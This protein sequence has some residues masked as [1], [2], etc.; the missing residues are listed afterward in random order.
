MLP[1]LG[2]PQTSALF[3]TVYFHYL[4]VRITLGF[5][6]AGQ[7]LG[8]NPGRR[9]VTPLDY[10][11]FGQEPRSAKANSDEPTY[12]RIIIMPRSS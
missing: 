4:S 1:V 5:H 12:T 10:S 7:S 8:F 6:R 2:K 3:R 9:I 11:G